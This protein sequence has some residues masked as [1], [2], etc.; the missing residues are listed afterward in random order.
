MKTEDLIPSDGEQP[1][2]WEIV[3]FSKGID[4]LG[5]AVKN[6][7]LQTTWQTLVYLHPEGRYRSSAPLLQGLCCGRPYK[8]ELSVT[9]GT[10]PPSPLPPEWPLW[11]SWGDS[12]Y[13]SLKFFDLF[14]CSQSVSLYRTV[15]YQREGS[16]TI[17]FTMLSVPGTGRVCSSC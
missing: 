8:H 10:P 15:S 4:F 17:L 7:D 2:P 14:T 13:H 6:S 9:W 12:S 16:L 3:S 1:L 5:T 11:N